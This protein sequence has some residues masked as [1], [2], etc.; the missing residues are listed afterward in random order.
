MYLCCAWASKNICRE[1]RNMKNCLLLSYTLYSC[2]GT[3]ILAALTG[4]LRYSDSPDQTLSSQPVSFR[5]DPVVPW[6][7]L[8]ESVWLPRANRYHTTTRARG[9]PLRAPL[10]GSAVSG[11]LRSQLRPMAVMETR[12]PF[13]LDKL[14]EIVPQLRGSEQSG[15]V[16]YNEKRHLFRR[17]HTSD[18]A[19][20]IHIRLR[21]HTNGSYFKIKAWNNVQYKK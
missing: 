14:T 6:V 15:N 1:N 7:H 3:F 2:S 21:T 5:V 20:G 10:A 4:L 8:H 9:F 16:V 17:R 11:A 18:C 13:T 12:E 19:T